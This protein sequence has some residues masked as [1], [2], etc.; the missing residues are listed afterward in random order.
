MGDNMVKL[1]IINSMPKTLAITAMCIEMATLEKSEPYR[2]ELLHGL[3]IFFINHEYNYMVI[4]LNHGI[5]MRDNYLTI[6][7]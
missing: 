7:Y 2:K 4:I 1:K 5:M 6:A 3:G